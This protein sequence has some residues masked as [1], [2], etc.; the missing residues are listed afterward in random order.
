MHGW[1]SG[2]P[3][4]LVEPLQEERQSTQTTPDMGDK[5]LYCAASD[6][7]GGGPA[8]EPVLCGIA[9]WPPA[10]A[11]FQASGR[12]MDPEQKPSISCDEPESSPGL[13]SNAFHPS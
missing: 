11:D 1:L 3:G 5:T 2:A 4:L 13:A 10:H 9:R 8:Q 6:T 7:G 12:H